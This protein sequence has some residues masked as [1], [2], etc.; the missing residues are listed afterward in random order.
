MYFARE[1]LPADIES[2][3]AKL[4]P[5][6]AEY[7]FEG[8]QT[9]NQLPA[10]FSVAIQRRLGNESAIASLRVELK[11]VLGSTDSLLYQKCLFD[12]TH[13]GDVVEH[14]LLDQL[15]TE[16]AR[17]LSKIGAQRRQLLRGFLREI[18]HLVRIAKREGNPIVFV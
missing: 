17:T 7:Y 3:G 8:P 13:S 15:E 14:E 11:S 16:I 12:G 9:R 4:N 5:T 10:G 6:T 1:S 18:T 2:M